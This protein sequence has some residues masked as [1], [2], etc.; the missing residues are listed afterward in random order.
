[1]EGHTWGALLESKEGKTEGS[2]MPE[3][4]LGWRK[5]ILEHLLIHF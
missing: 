5:E 4:D 1:M 3:Q 2:R